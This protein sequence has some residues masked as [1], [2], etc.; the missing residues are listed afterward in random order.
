MSTEKTMSYGNIRVH[1][2]GSCGNH[3]FGEDLWRQLKRIEL[4][5]FNRDKRS[6]R[7][8]KAVFMA[9]VDTAPATGEYKL[10]QLRQCLSREALNVIENLGHSA[11]AYEKSKRKAMNRNWYNQ[12]ANP[13]LNTKAGN[14]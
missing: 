10:L 11:T 7:N 6:Y 8:W 9:C 4:P 13:A 3:S 14:K 1:E 5:V 2:S 12:K